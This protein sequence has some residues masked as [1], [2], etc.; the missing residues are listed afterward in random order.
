M[1]NKITISVSGGTASFGSVSLNA[2]T[3]TNVTYASVDEAFSATL[4]RLAKQSVD[5]GT[6]SAE[7]AQVV[8]LLAK[9]KDFGQQGEKESLKARTVLEVI[10]KNFSWA[11]TLAKDFALYVFPALL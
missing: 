9:L 1:G 5:L 3:A 10:Q 6:Q 7:Y 2:D 11:Y 4:S 8:A